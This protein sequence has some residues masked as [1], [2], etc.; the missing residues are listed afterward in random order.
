VFW[1]GARKILPW[2]TLFE[3]PKEHR[4]ENLT[5]KF[6]PIWNKELEKDKLHFN[7]PHH[8]FK[9]KLYQSLFLVCILWMALL[10]YS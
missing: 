3:L 5:K 1:T 4:T 10:T 9:T 6:D 7:F 2:K 8:F